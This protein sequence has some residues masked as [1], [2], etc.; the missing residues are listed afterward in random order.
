MFDSDSELSEPA[1]IPETQLEPILEPTRVNLKD[2][3][4][5]RLMHPDMEPSSEPEIPLGPSMR[6]FVT[7]VLEP[8]GHTMEFDMQHL[9][10]ARLFQEIEY[11]LGQE[12]DA[13]GSQ[14][15]VQ[16]VHYTIDGSRECILTMDGEFQEFRSR[17]ACTKSTTHIA[18]RL[19]NPEVSFLLKGGPS[20]GW[21]G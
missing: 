1:T 6:R 19:V 15:V 21:I 12:P 7:V 16:G 13:D 3:K 17:L 8:M 14:P 18:I 5:P 10:M 20:E 4:I 2:H 9:T 11:L